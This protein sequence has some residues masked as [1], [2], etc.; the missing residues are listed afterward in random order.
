MT[1]R[2]RERGAALVLVMWLVAAMAITVGGALALS[3][4]EVSLASSRLGEAKVYALG[5]GIARLAVLDRAVLKERS[6]RF[7]T[8]VRTRS[9]TLASATAC[10]AR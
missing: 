6:E 9:R 8:H 7:N 2:R 4:E 3:R 1:A 10:S 5:K